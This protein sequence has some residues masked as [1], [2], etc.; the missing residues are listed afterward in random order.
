MTVTVS[1][2]QPSAFPWIGQFQKLYLSDVHVIL[3]DVSFQKAGFLHR[4]RVKAPSGVRHLTVP[5]ANRSSNR[6]IRDIEVSAT[7]DLQPLSS[8]FLSWYRPAPEVDLALSLLTEYLARVRADGLVPAA[9]ATV[10]AISMHLGLQAPV[11]V[12][13]STVGVA[14]TGTE[15]LVDL[16]EALAG[17]R[18][19]YGPGTA[20]RPQYMQTELLERAGIEP[21]IMSYPDETYPQLHGEFVARLS[22]LDCIANIGA[23]SSRSLVA[24]VA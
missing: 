6:A 19:V 14:S 8:S 24:R 23:E 5:L 21:V 16:V 13:S 18:Y 2:C 20:G 7:A 3:D 4:V 11:L 10:N 22:V 12:R 17:E 9:I 15:R 1:I